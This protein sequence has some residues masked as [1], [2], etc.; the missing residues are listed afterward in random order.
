MLKIEDRE[1][2][3]GKYEVPGTEE[4]VQAGAQGRGRAPSLMEERVGHRCR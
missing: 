4:A 2:D 1:R 3:E